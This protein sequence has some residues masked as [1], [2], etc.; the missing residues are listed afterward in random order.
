MFMSLPRSVLMTW[1]STSCVLDGCPVPMVS[2]LTCGCGSGPPSQVNDSQPCATQPGP[3]CC[4]NIRGMRH[5]SSS[6]HLSSSNSPR[7]NS[8]SQLNSDRKYSLQAAR[9][10]SQTT[11]SNQGS[12]RSLPDPDTNAPRKFPFAHTLHAAPISLP[13]PPIHE[14]I[15]ATTAAP[16][17]RGTRTQTQSYLFTPLGLLLVL[18]LFSI[19]RISMGIAVP[20]TPRNCD[21]A[22]ERYVRAERGSRGWRGGESGWGMSWSLR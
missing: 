5:C 11:T 13:L 20:V 9:I 3:Q 7:E 22:E 19:L 15:A 10:K 2:P 12:K 14:L 17:S 18:P 1:R 6:L 21:R 8:L 4:S 16:S